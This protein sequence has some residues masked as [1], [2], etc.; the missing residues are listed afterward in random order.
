MRDRSWSR[1]HIGSGSFTLILAGSLGNL[2]NLFGGLVKMP[3]FSLLTIRF[4]HPETTHF[5]MLT[6][7]W[8][9]PNRTDPANLAPTLFKAARVFMSSFPHAPFSG[10]KRCVFVPE[11]QQYM[12]EPESNNGAP[13]CVQDVSLQ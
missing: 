11:I 10:R 9:A 4:G 7:C 8:S 1:R 2:K 3:R 12:D 5:T 13:P 6:V